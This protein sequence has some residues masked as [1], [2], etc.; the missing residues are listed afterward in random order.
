[1]VEQHT[2]VKLA[3]RYQKEASA[4]FK[5]A[6][7][8]TRGKPPPGF[9][10]DLRSEA[11]AMLDEAR[12][13][14]AR[15]VERILDETTIHCG[16]LTGLDSEILGRRY[17]DLLVID[18]ACQSTEPGGWI[19]VLRA[20]KVVLAGD[21]C[22]LPPTIL[23][24]EAMAEGFGISMLERLVGLYGSQITRRLGV[25]YRMHADIMG[26]SS[27]E[28]YD[29]ELVADE[30][31]ATHLLKDLP[32][33]VTSPL[34]ETPIEFID[35][36]GAGYDEEKETNGESK[37]NP[38][39]AA[40]VILRVQELMQAGLDPRQIA[41]IAPYSAQVRLLRERLRVTGLEVA[42]VDG[43]QGRE[44]EAVVISLVRS[45][46]IGEVGFLGDVRRLN[47]A[48][49]RARRKLIVIGDSATLSTLPFFRRL[50]EYFEALGAYRTVWEMEV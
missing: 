18:E 12:R 31:V 26:F 6:A 4:L 45:N 15:A 42:S 16:T 48:L 27:K 39:E 1:M 23:S 43:W 21:H 38:Q 46:P 30:S 10:Q 8:F 2:D 17:Y 44:A 41:V 14:E 9:K 25:Q 22:Q 33:V 49:T 13:L 35:T 7:K 36:A 37:F 40:L 3:R 28:F 47:V 20:N 24:R 11:R 5:Q 29:G 34:T 19:P 32:G 50:L